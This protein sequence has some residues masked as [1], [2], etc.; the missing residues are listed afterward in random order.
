[1]Q[2]TRKLFS[3]EK[4]AE[5]FAATDR[6]DVAVTSEFFHD[7]IEIVLGNNEP[8]RGKA[9]HAR[10]SDQVKNLL[11]GIRHEIHD[12]WQ[13][14]G[15]D[16]TIIAAMTVHYTRLDDNVVSVPCSNIFR[17]EDGLIRHY[18]VYVD[19]APVFA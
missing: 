18:Q 10:L 16:Q 1:M 5:L 14:A 17:L 11:K 7:D 9:G 6:F 8:V 2:D 13:A 19:M 3:V 15:D 12:V 4:V